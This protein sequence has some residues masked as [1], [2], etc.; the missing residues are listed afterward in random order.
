MNIKKITWIAIAIFS[1]VFLILFAFSIQRNNGEFVYPIDDTYIHM[2]IANNTADYGM[3]GI[4]K[5]SFSAT[6]S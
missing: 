3:W 5:Y 2:A 6:S 4:D 1:I